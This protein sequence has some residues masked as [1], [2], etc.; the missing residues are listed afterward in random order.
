MFAE[1]DRSGAP[2]EE[3]YYQQRALF[4]RRPVGE[5]FD[6]LEEAARLLY[7]DRTGFNGL[8][9]ENADDGFNV[10]IGRH[11]SVD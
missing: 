1:T 8:Y 10:P 3:F 11:Q 9:R 7:L 6:P 2:V 5:A 4:N